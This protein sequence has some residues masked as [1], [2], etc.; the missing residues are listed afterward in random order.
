MDELEFGMQQ[1]TKSRWVYEWPM[2]MK[3]KWSVKELMARRQCRL[4]RGWLRHI[5]NL[6]G[7]EELVQVCELETGRNLSD[8]EDELESAEDLKDCQEDSQKIPNC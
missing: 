2:K 3:E 7:P 8:A 6:D 5:E 4:L 1:D